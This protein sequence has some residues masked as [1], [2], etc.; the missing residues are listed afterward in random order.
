MVSLFT[1]YFVG[2]HFTDLGPFIANADC[3]KTKLR[4]FANARLNGYRDWLSFTN[5]FHTICLIDRIFKQYA[6]I[7][8]KQTRSH[9]RESRFFSPNETNFL[10]VVCV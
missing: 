4:R 3:L 1:Y 5:I 8:R 2:Y 6:S 10:C 7:N 9:I